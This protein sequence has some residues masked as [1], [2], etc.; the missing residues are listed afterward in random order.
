[1]RSRGSTLWHPGSRRHVLGSRFHLA[2]SPKV[3]L[4]ESK[5]ELTELR[6]ALRVLQKEKEQLQEEKQVR[7]QKRPWMPE[8]RT[9]GWKLGVFL[10]SLDLETGISK[11][12]P[13][14][15]NGTMAPLRGLPGR[16][17]EGCWGKQGGHGG[18]E[19]CLKP[20]HLLMKA[21]NSQELRDHPGRG[22][23]F[24]GLPGSYLLSLSH[25]SPLPGTAGVHEK[26]GGPPREGG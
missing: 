20:S 24:V 2:L 1:M 17:G 9:E 19:I 11:K 21:S 13:E 22:E 5:R 7:A 18:V 25:F 14:A 16:I 4:S 8:R 26:A 15:K 10:S 6:S 3:Q 23:G 12:G